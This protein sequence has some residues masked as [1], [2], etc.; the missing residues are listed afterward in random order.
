M[1]RHYAIVTCS[2]SRRNSNKYQQVKRENSCNSI[3][4]IDKW[5][6]TEN[7]QSPAIEL[8]RNTVNHTRWTYRSCQKVRRQPSSKCSQGSQQN[9]RKNFSLMRRCCFY[10]RRV[11]SGSLRC[12]GAFM[13]LVQKEQGCRKLQDELIQ[14]WGDNAPDVTVFMWLWPHLTHLWHFV[15]VLK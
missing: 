5:R 1:T 11:W 6:S 7:Q 9:A 13:S 12:L 4:N 10:L 2:W 15:I 3:L 14:E 8:L